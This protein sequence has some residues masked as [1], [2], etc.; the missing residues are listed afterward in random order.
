[1]PLHPTDQ[2]DPDGPDDATVPPGSPDDATLPPERSGDATELPGSA[3]GSHAPSHGERAGDEIGPY[4]LVSQLGEGGFGTVWLA[5]R[6][7]PFVQQVALKLIK[8]GMDSKSVLAR[9]EQE[10]QA[11]A[12]MNHPHVAKVL[13]GGLTPAGRPYFAMEFVKG[14]PISRYCDSNRLS[15]RERLELF[16]Q[17]CDAVQHAHVKGLIHRDLKPGNVLVMRGDG[18][19]PQAKV[20]DFGVAKALTRHL[21]EHTF[22]TETGQMIGTPEYMS[23]EQSE[24][25]ATDI[26]TRSDVYSLGVMLYELL[27]GALPFDP[28]ELRS[29]AYREIQRI[30][31]EDD[32][33]SP[34]ARLSTIA[35]RDGETATRIAL[36]RQ[37]IAANLARELKSELEWIPLKAMRKDRA[38]RYDSAAALARDVRNYLDGRPLEAAPESTAYRLRKAVRR[39][40]ALFATLA[41]VAA[42]LVIGL[43]LALWQWNRAETERATA[44]RTVRFLTDDILRAADPELGGADTRL[45]DLLAPAAEA[46]D[47][48]FAGDALA[49]A[50]TSRAIGEAYLSLGL[51]DEA[52]AVLEMELH[53]D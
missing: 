20:I 44:E 47:R 23:P 9:F 45:A 43:G 25:D 19:R 10:R 38:R 29:K 7:K 2:N 41:T 49:A 6:R 33:P 48:R 51:P 3:R 26:D 5:E 50:R 15:I 18:D 42:S 39:H 1:M 34:S 4:H 8:A 37:A 16:M 40:R 12:L 13:D 35:T 11:L 30:I 27:A 52:L 53:L 31:R 17:V 46:I 28:K 36:A 24:P 14:E 32:P 22:F 21:S